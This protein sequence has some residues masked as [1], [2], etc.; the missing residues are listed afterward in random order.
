M[1]IG[2]PWKEAVLV[3]SSDTEGM[4]CLEEI[5]VQWALV[6]GTGEGRRVLANHTFSLRGKAHFQ[7]LSGS[8][9][10]G[11]SFISAEGEVDPDSLIAGVWEQ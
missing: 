5:P 9:V 4:V 7:V 2:I 6:A 11:A 8:A 3:V 1:W 10:I